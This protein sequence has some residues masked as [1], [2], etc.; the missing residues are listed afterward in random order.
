LPALLTIANTYH[1]L[2]YKSFRGA[3]RVQQLLRQ[4]EKLAQTIRKVDV[5]TIGADP[6]RCGLKGSPTIVAQVEKVEESTRQCR[7]LFG[8]AKK[9]VALL[10]QESGIDRF[11]VP[12]EPGVQP[13]AACR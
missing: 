1:P 11:L 8:D 10:R 7:L 6:L 2:E 3:W 13:V 4:P 5:D 12:V 9:T